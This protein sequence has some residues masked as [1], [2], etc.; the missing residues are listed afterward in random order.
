[1]GDGT[2]QVPT[3]TALLI[4]D[5]QRRVMQTS[6]RREL[7]QLTR[8]IWNA[9]DNPKNAAGLQQLR[10]AIEARRAMVERGRGR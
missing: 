4:R 8:S 1:M 9:F 6:N 2:E 7:D 3:L 5:Y 10:A